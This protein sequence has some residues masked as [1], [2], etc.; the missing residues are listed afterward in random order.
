MGK[1]LQRSLGVGC[2]NPK[3]CPLQLTIAKTSRI[4]TEVKQICAGLS[5]RGLI[6]DLDARHGYKSCIDQYLAARRQLSEAKICPS[7]RRSPLFHTPRPPLSPPHPT[8]IRAPAS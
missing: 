3:S 7:G 4:V 6:D 8:L 1:H 2:K 5:N